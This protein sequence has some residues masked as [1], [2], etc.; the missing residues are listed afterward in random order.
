MT[1]D[2]IAGSDQYVPRHEAVREHV[3]NTRHARGNA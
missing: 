3:S 2:L 1:A